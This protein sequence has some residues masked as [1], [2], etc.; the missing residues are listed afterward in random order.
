MLY[1][2]KCTDGKENDVSIEVGS[3]EGELCLYRSVQLGRR[4]MSQ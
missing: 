4:M 2:Q 1:L 3:W